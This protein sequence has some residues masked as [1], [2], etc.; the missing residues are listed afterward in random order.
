MNTGMIPTTRVPPPAGVIGFNTAD[1]RVIGIREAATIPFVTLAKATWAAAI[2]RSVVRT[3]QI[4]GE[5]AADRANAETMRRQRDEAVNR[6]TYL[7]ER[8][9][10]K[11]LPSWGPD[12]VDTVDTVAVIGATVTE[13]PAKA[14]RPR[15][16]AAERG[17]L[18]AEMDRRAGSQ[19]PGYKAIARAMSDRFSREFTAASVGAMARRLRAV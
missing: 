5:Q 17:F 3:R 4:M 6:A 15:W 18:A 2:G 19:R 11:S 13:P 1:G 10:A 9:H 12:T 7:E 16:T 8:L 14:R